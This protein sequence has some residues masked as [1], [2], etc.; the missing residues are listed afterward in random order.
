M[1]EATASFLGTVTEA[2]RGDFLR[3]ALDGQEKE[4]KHVH[5]HESVSR[6]KR[7]RGRVPKKYGWDAILISIVFRVSWNFI[8]SRGRRRKTIRSIRRTACGRASGPSRRGPSR[9]NFGPRTGVPATRQLGRSIWSIRNLR[10]S[11]YS[12]LSPLERRRPREP[13]L[14]WHHSRPRTPSPA[15]SAYVAG[16]NSGT[17]K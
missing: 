17:I 13:Q 11:R 15:M 7:F 5:C 10:A 8:C 14:S 16:S 9:K 4:T 2:V 1:K 3:V 6:E 12:R